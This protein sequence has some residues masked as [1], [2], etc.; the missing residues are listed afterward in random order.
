MPWAK[1]PSH[2]TVPLRDNANV[3]LHRRNRVIEQ[4]RKK[5]REILFDK[6][7]ICQKCSSISLYVCTADYENSFRFNFA[8]LLRRLFPQASLYHRITFFSIFL[9][10]WAHGLSPFS[11]ETTLG[12][13]RTNLTIMYTVYC[14]NVFLVLKMRDIRNFFAGK[15]HMG[16]FQGYFKGVIKVEAPLL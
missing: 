2:A 10:T 5:L 3:Y 16:H 1:K 11:Q 12:R 4:S 13:D 7:I 14:N 9:D 15:L 6:Q 8:S